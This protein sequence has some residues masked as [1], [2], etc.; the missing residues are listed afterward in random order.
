VSLLGPKDVEAN[1]YREVETTQTDNLL[2]SR[3]RDSIGERRRPLRPPRGCHQK[4]RKKQLKGG[5]EPPTNSPLWV[6][7]TLSWE[8]CR[9]WW[10]WGPV[11]V[12]QPRCNADT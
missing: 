7:Q 11:F 4:G 8:K 9:H 1:S 6:K 3:A 10:T 2:N 5:G 12:H